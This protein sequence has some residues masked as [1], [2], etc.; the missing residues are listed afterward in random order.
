M[1][2]G[3]RVLLDYIE[4]ITFQREFWVVGCVRLGVEFFCKFSH[5][6]KSLI[7]SKRLMIQ[8]SS[9]KKLF[10]SL[11]LYIKYL[12]CFATTRQMV[13]IKL[14]TLQKQANH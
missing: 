14:H 4:S 12:A 7:T 2:E 3:G 9:I 11:S 8:S 10:E 13:P 1:G 6:I 5:L